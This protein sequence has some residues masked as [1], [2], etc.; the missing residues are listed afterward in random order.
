MTWPE[1]VRLSLNGW[2]IKIIGQEGEK[3]EQLLMNKELKKRQKY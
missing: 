3:V 1:L 2:I